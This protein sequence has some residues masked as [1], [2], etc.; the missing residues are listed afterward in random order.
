MLAKILTTHSFLISC[1]SLAINFLH[2]STSCICPHWNNLFNLSK[3]FCACSLDSYLMVLTLMHMSLASMLPYFCTIHVRNFVQSIETR[4]SFLNHSLTL[5]LK[6]NLAIL[7]SKWKHT[8]PPKIVVTSIIFVQ[9]F[10]LVMYG[11]HI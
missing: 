4:F 5:S 9:F 11:H 2:C 8:K 1:L 6:F 3:Y 7:N 10:F